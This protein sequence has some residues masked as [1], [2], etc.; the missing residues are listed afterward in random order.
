MGHSPPLEQIDLRPDPEF[1]IMAGS[2]D[3]RDSN[4]MAHPED[5]K[6]D[7]DRLTGLGDQPP[8]ARPFEHGLQALGLGTRQ[9]EVENPASD[10]LDMGADS[11]PGQLS[12][13]SAALTAQRMRL[14]DLERSLVDRIADVD[15]DRRRGEGI[16]HRA[17]EAQRASL[18]DRLR[19]RAWLTLSG[20]ILLLAVSAAVF[21]LQQQRIQGIEHR[22]ETE[23]GALRQ[24]LTSAPADGGEQT[25]VRDQLDALSRSVTEIRGQLETLSRSVTED[26][27]R[28]D[29]LSRTVTDVSATV[30]PLAAAQD[31]APAERSAATVGLKHQIEQLEGEQ[32]RLIEE[33]K[34][35][36]SSPPPQQPN[37]KPEATLDGAELDAG[38]ADEARAALV[39][40]NA[41]TAESAPPPRDDPMPATAD[42]TADPAPIETVTDRPFALQLIGFHE[43]SE[44]LAFVATA[45]L[46]QRIYIRKEQLRGRPW[47]ALIHSLHP[48]YEAAKEATQD[49][50]ADLIALEPW[51]RALPEGDRL[52]LIE[53]SNPR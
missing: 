22:L 9:P 28:L 39:Q 7:Q 32:R 16:L 19:R 49:L 29:A 20:L 26:R 14:Q 4:I 12:T 23:I 18:D 52:E 10:P 6:N 45:E 17:S 1:W 46:P 21:L 38:R 42:A 41:P 48:S 36:R 30:E 47:Y 50:P 40:T 27:G 15:D 13:L 35:L 5:T 44:L 43:R 53:T 37:A 8:K 24:D 51:I 11:V 25:E 34:A 33:L 2:T 3:W 31:R